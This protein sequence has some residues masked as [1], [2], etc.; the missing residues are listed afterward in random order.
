[1][2][3]IYIVFLNIL[4]MGCISDSDS[5]S[6]SAPD[7]IA[8]IIGTWK[9]TVASNGCTRSLTFKKDKTWELSSLDEISSG[10][11]TLS[12][13]ASFNN[14][15]KLALQTI[16]DNGLPDCKGESHDKTGTSQ[17]TYIVFDGLTAIKV[18]PSETATESFFDGKK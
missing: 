13:E 15:F 14:R 4:L 17:V 6:N 9:N 7:E 11:Y 12:D 5:N 2:K 18:Y 10:T 8:S 1:V 16:K 3:I